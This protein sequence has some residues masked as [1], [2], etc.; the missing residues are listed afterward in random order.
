MNRLITSAALVVLL[1]LGGGTA[2]IAMPPPPP[3]PHGPPP[4][5]WPPHPYQPNIQFGIQFGGGGY[6]YYDDQDY[7]VSGNAIYNHL[8][9]MGY[10]YLH[11]VDDNDDTLTYTGKLGSKRYWLE[12]DACSGELLDRHRI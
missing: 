11:L 8:H 12:V 10:R 5:H 4:P 7:C 1:A 9:R 3:P 6:D 2:A